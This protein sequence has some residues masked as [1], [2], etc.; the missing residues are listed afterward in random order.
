MEITLRVIDYRQLLGRENELI[1]TS[2]L[3]EFCVFVLLFQILEDEFLHFG[4]FI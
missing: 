3:L 1:H 4:E 2:D